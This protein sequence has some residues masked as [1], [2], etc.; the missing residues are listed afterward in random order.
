MTQTSSSFSRDANRQP[1]WT[2]GIVTSKSITYAAA[3]TGA[4]GATTLFT[5]TGD[6]LVSVF[7]VCSV[8]LDSDGTPTLEVGITDNTA[9]LL[10]QLTDATA[11][12]AGEIYI[13]TS[14]ATVESFPSA[15]ILTNGTDIIQTIGSTT[16]KAGTVTYYCVW[17]PISSDGNV[18]AA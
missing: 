11:L 13:D 2:D 4:T 10:A 12:D 5:I 17:R 15:K 9:A 14:P 16:I 1:I 18:V 8:S 6:V 3:T 7:A